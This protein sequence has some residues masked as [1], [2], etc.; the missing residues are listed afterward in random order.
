MVRYGTGG[1]C[2][3]FMNPREQ[4]EIRRQMRAARR[5]LSR[6]DLDIAGARLARNLQSLP[7]YRRARTIGAYLAVGGEMPLQPLILDAWTHGKHV[8]LPRLRDAHLDFHRYTADTRLRRNRFGIAEPAVT[9]HSR[10][11]PRFIDVVLVPLVAFDD[12]GNRL[13]MGGGF[14]DRSFAFL[15]DRRCWRRPLLIGIAHEFQHLPAL[16]PAPWDVPLHA[17]VTDE[18][19]RWFRN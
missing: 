12:Q 16:D 11:N 5:A 2:P 10:I 19:V 8:Y 17:A 13:G 7:A 3:F 6:Q 15:H 18:Q 1:R 4:Q 14:Y 9:A